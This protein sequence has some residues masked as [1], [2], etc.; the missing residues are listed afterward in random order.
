TVAL[1]LADPRFYH[2][3]TCLCPL[4][5]GYVMYFPPAFDDESQKLIAEIVPENK[6]IVVSEDDAL[7]FSCNA[8]DL[9]NHVFMNG[10]SA[11]L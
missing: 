7:L 6:R 3:D 10:A 11:K 2:L 8:V 4:T 5:G 1:K 9:N